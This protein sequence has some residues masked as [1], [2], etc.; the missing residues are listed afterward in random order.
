MDHQENSPHPEFIFNLSSFG[1]HHSPIYG[2][3][4]LGPHHSFS[5]AYVRACVLSRFGCVRLCDP[6]DCSQP[7]LSMGFSRQEY[8]SGLPCPPPGD[9][10]NPGIE[11]ASLMS[12]ALA[13]GFFTTSATWE[14]PPLLR[15]PQS[16][17]GGTSA[18]L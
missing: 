3:L 4:F 1:H 13:G 18:G 7:P 8:W 5:V 17:M 10:P 2:H 14:A 9:L 11:P 6:M 15:N 16:S 12:P